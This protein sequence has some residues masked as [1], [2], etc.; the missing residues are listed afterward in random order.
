M[1][2]DYRQG[3]DRRRFRAKQAISPNAAP[4][5]PISSVAAQTPKQN[6]NGAA[7]PPAPP[8]A[9]FGPNAESPV[10]VPLGP[11]RQLFPP[12]P[13][14]T[15]LGTSAGGASLQIPRNTT[16][17]SA[18]F[19]PDPNAAAA[20]PNGMIVATYNTGI[21]YSTDGGA[22][23]TDVP[24]FGPQPGNPARTSFFPQSDGGLCCDQVVVYLAAQNL[25]A[26]LQQYNPVTACAT[27]CPPQPPPAPA[28]T[29]VVTQSPRL[30]C[31]GYAG[32]YCS[33][34]LECLDVCRSYRYQCGRVRRPGYPTNGIPVSK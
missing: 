24:L 30:S 6:P 23:F 27:N 17:R 12:T 10:F 1:E 3:D 11:P 34:F 15:A 9:P 20:A 2:G 19:P 28:S 18:G 31:V 16:M 32:Q 7:Y 29:F 25:F 13:T 5:G 33:R 26:W 21:S 8:A 4:P 14:G 22:T